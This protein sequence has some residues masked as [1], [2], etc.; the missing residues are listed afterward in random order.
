MKYIFILSGENI[1]LA[2]QEVL[3]L[4]DSKK[5]SLKK[6]QLKIDITEKT[7]EFLKKRL[8]LTHKIICNN[9]EIEITKSFLKRKPHLRPQLH[10]SSLNPK[11][12]KALINITGIKKGKLLDP[13]CGSAGILIEAAF[14]DLKPIG[15]DIDEV[16]LRRAIINLT[17]YKIKNFDLKLKDA[18]KIKEKH[19]YI[20]TDLPYGKNTASKDLN[21]LYSSFLK[22]LKLILKKKAV[23][24]FPDFIDYKKL[25]K[26]AKLK[27]EKEFDYYLHKSLSKKIILINN[28]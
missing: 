23:I 5:Y 11:L 13:F 4:T 25:I 27:I 8:A 10:P 24:S 15:Y 14:M 2:K 17:H 20:V 28:K 7:L 26:S 3:A 12:A 9:K 6:N 22:N 19:D 1:D 18:T 21:K 16:M